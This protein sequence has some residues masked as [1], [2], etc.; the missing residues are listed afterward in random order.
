MPASSPSLDMLS[1]IEKLIG[2]SAI[3]VATTAITAVI[4]IGPDEISLA[5]TEISAVL[6]VSDNG[7]FGDEIIKILNLPDSMEP[8]YVNVN[9]FSAKYRSSHDRDYRGNTYRPRRDLV[10][11]DRD[12]RRVVGQR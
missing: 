11:R 9:A 7:A 10:G 6:S 1:A 2:A 3:Y 12:F 8:S 4:P 5:A